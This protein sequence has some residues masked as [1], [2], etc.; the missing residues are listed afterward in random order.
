[1]CVKKTRVRSCHTRVTASAKRPELLVSLTLWAKTAHHETHDRSMYT[2]NVGFSDFFT[3][4][5]HAG[6]RGI[7]LTW[8]LCVL[9][10]KFAYYVR[11][12][13]SINIHFLIMAKSFCNSLILL[14]TLR[15]CSLYIYPIFPITP[16]L[17]IFYCRLFLSWFLWKAIE[18]KDFL[19]LY[20]WATPLCKT[21]RDVDVGVAN[22]FSQRGQFFCANAERAATI[23]L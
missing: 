10:G 18:T 19:L 4:E 1:M 20:G 3:T 9:R 2:F 11:L 14:T 17:R 8:F 23:I 22:T 7:T 15:S 16:I 5:V 12:Y 6:V 21:F 13:M